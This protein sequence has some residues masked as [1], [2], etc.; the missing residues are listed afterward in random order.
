MSGED[1]ALTDDERTPGYLRRHWAKADRQDKRRIHLLEHHLA[2]VAACVEALL[3]LPIVS[4]RLART[5]HR[6]D[7]DK[8]TAA[9]LAVMAALHDIGKANVGFQTNIWRQED[10]PSRRRP[11]Q[12][13]WVGHDAVLAPVLNGGDRQTCQWFFD[14]LGWCDDMACWDD[15]GG[16]TASALF[17]AALSHHGRPLDLYGSTPPNPRL[18]RSFGNLDP[19]RCVQSI[20]RQVRDWFPNA[21]A[22]DAPPLPAAPAFQHL[23]LGLVTLADWIGSDERQ[24]P[25]VDEPR[26][27][28]IRT[29]RRQARRALQTI[30]LDVANQRRAFSGA[31]RFAD[32]FDIHGSP[33]P[34][35]IQKQAAWNTPLDEPVVVIESETGSG[36]TE[37]ALWRFARMYE[38][39]LVDGLYF[40]LPTRAAASQMH[41]RVQGFAARMF[42]AQHQPAPVLAVPGYVRAGDVSGRH[43]PGFDV[44]WDDDPDPAARG[45]RWAAE[46]AK[47]FLA[48]QIA[49]GTV[50]QAMLA[51]L[52]VKHAH[53]RAACLA[54][55]LLVVDEVHASDPYMRVILEALLNAQVGAGGFALLMS[56]TLGSAARRRWLLRPRRES[57]APTLS[58]AEAVATAYPAVSIQG[59]D[60]ETVAGAG[61]NDRNRR[62]CIEARPT[63]HAFDDAAELALRA[64]RRGAKVLVVRNTVGHAVQTQQAVEAAAAGGGQRLLFALDGAPTLHTSRFAADD[65]R[66]LDAAVERQLGKQRPPGGRVVVGTQTLEQ[67]LDIDADLLIT[68]LCPLDVLLQRIGR[69]HRHDRRDRPDVCREPT[70]VVLL[71]PHDDLT[72]LLAKQR[73]GASRNGLG[74]TVY[75]DLRILELTRRL[76]VDHANSGQPWRIPAMNRELVERATHPDELKTLVEEMQDADEAWTTHDLDV[77]GARISDN[78]FA[79]GAV[80][81]RCRSF[82][83]PDVRFANV[84]QQIRTRLGGEGVELEFDPPSPGPFAASPPIPKLALPDYMCRGLDADFEHPVEPQRTEDGEDGFEFTLGTARFVYDRLG[85]RRP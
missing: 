70:C 40:A 60:A 14:E 18:W 55:N 42:P 83:D 16:Q 49:V 85:L 27:G 45:R 17:T 3:A 82:L 61:E 75:P 23:F 72:P 32:L 8:A 31:P 36:K 46:S 76:V 73:R 26:G 35:A 84:E 19:R 68:D 65:R 38:Q 54:R 20:G 59:A 21:F 81:Q 37:A 71:P 10:L 1:A 44:W 64:A 2:D 77:D 39:G 79:K 9:R 43:L 41:Q 53:L 50:D 51:A 11:S 12:D 7:L 69:L 57:Q 29:A 47:R 34:N 62:V 56:A 80:V 58:L 13:R 4:Q 67:S 74:G 52:Q 63:M 24:F 30:G 22:A 48:A 25:F 66:R 6:N 33:P 15:N 5:A 28:Y 78:Q